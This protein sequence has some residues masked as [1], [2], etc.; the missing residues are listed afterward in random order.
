M[1]LD[2][3][4]ISLALIK[5]RWLVGITVEIAAYNQLAWTISAQKHAKIGQ[6]NDNT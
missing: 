1:I 5:T 6:T 4:Q 2:W 3:V